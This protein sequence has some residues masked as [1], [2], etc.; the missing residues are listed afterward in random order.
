MGDRTARGPPPWGRV[1]AGHLAF[2]RGEHAHG[3]KN[4]NDSPGGSHPRE[5]FIL[6][7]VQVISAGFRRIPGRPGGGGQNSKTGG[8]GPG[9]NGSVSV[10]ERLV[11]TGGKFRGTPFCVCSN[12]R[13]FSAGFPKRGPKTPRFL[14]ITEPG[15]TGTQRPGAP[16]PRPLYMRAV[17]G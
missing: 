4:T 10:A 11:G 15:F 5:Y 13:V 14:P 2:Y 1:C 8:K 16:A 17:L 12:G 3:Q 6:P 9:R 7:H